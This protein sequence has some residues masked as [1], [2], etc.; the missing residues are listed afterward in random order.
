[1]YALFS[2]V[3]KASPLKIKGLILMIAFP[4]GF[5]VLR[6]FTGISDK[7]LVLYFLVFIAGI[8]SAR[9]RI[10]D[11]ITGPFYGT[12]GIILI[13]SCVLYSRF[14]YPPTILASR[15]PPLFSF[16]SLMALVVTNIIMIA[17]I[18]VSYVLFKQRW[19][20]RCS[21][22]FSFVA[23]ASYCMYLFHRPFWWGLSKIYYPVSLAG[24]QM[25][26]VASIPILIIVCFFI[27]KRYD[28]LLK[29]TF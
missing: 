3:N 28:G 19:M 11:K 12:I 29:K 2:T 18:P 15:Q 25:Y 27:Q 1:V 26:S 4:L 14:I 20:A 17:V 9:R 8:F 23:Y 5:V 24:Q 13:I 21:S 22:V 6:Y 7:R 16:I 10:L